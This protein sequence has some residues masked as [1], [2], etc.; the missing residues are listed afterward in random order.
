[1]LYWISSCSAHGA[2]QNTKFCMAQVLNWN[3]FKN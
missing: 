1:L 3:F 2:Y